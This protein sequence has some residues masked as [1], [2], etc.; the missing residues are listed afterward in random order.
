MDAVIEDAGQPDLIIIPS[1]SD[2]IIT[3]LVFNM[4]F[5][6]W[7]I[8]NYLQ[9][10]ESVITEHNGIHTYRNKYNH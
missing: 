2:E 9:Q 8:R 4:R 1:I 7:L 10:D 6:P 3:L 5:N